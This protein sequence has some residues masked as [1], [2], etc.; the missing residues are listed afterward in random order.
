MV[1]YTDNID[2][3]ATSAPITGSPRHCDK[4]HRFKVNFNNS[5]QFT[6]SAMVS[7]VDYTNPNYSATSPVYTEIKTHS[8]LATTSIGKR[9]PVIAVH[10]KQFTG[11][12]KIN[13]Q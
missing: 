13:I 5:M 10:R 1:G 8:V 4:I 11:N 2:L 3:F 9:W 12:V 6:T 7:E